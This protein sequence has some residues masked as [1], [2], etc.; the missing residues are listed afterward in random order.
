MNGKPVGEHLG[1]GYTAFTLDIT[2]AL[3]YGAMNQVE[4]KADNSFN[5]AMLP[6]GRSSDWAHDGGIYRPV[7]LLVSPSTYLERVDVDASP[8]SIR[9]NALVRGGTS[10]LQITVVDET[11]GAVVF[12]RSDALKAGDN[13]LAPFTLAK[14]K[15]WHF[16]HHT[17][18]VWS[19]AF[20]AGTVTLRRSG[21]ARLRLAPMGST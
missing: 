8:Q 20:R 12:E 4:V 17:C 13:L 1:K 18:T 2:P 16:D 11:T 19:A 9:V 10:Q 7:Q 3:N 14:P 21:Y 5:E 6:R 15:L